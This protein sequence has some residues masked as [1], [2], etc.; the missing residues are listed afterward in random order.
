[1]KI[2]ACG[3]T[4]RG[5]I[6]KHNEDNIYIDG[7]F[8]HD[9]SQDNVLIKSKRETGPYTYAVFDGLGGEACGEQASL[10]AALGLKA[11]DERASVGNVDTYISTAHRAILQESVRKNARHMGTTAVAVHINEKRAMVFNVGDS[12]AYLFRNGNLMQLSK[13]HSV[14]QSMIDC[15]LMKESERNTSRYAGELTQYIGMV[16][17]EDIE[18]SAFVAEFKLNSGD[19]ILLCSDGLSGELNDSE[20]CDLL[21]INKDKTPDYIVATLLK[22]VVDGAARDNVSAVICKIE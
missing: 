8:R 2:T 1:M 19:C 15:G 3:A 10:I 11:V 6:R 4:H 20:I 7:S 5:N 12:R 22:K 18:P 16:T 21:R 17:E 9:L 13:D 14:V